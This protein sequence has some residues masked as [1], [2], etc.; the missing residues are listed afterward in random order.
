MTALPDRMDRCGIGLRAPHLDAV[1]G[2]QAD[3]A[4]VEIHAENHMLDGPGGDRLAAVRRD[5]PVSIHGVGLSLGSAG[6][7][8]R[9]HLSRL[10]RL[11]ERVE[12]VLVSEHLAWSVAG[13]HYWNDLLP[14]PLTAEALDVMAANVALVQD[15]LKRPILV[16]N[17]SSYLSFE[18]SEMGEGEFL[19][20]LARRTGCGVLLDLNNLYLS[21]CNLGRDPLADLEAM[22]LGC[23]GE[24]HLAGHTLVDLGDAQIRIDDHGSAVADAVW[25]LFALT[26]RRL[27]P[28]PALVEWDSAL[29][30]SSDCWRKPPRLTG[31][32]FRRRAMRL[33][34]LQGTFAQGLRTGEMPPALVAQVGAS[35]MAPARRLA[36]HRNHVRIT[37]SAA[38]ALHFPVVARLV[39]NEAFAAIANRFI[40]AHPPTDPVLSRFGALLPDFL[41]REEALS[42]L[43]Y[44]AAVAHLEWARHGAALAPSRAV[45]SAL[46]LAGIAPADLDTLSLALPPSAALIQSRWAVDRLWLANQE[47]C[48]GT[49]DGLIDEARRLAVWRDG[50]DMIRVAR[51]GEGDWAFLDAVA[52]GARLGDAAAAVVRAGAEAEL[53]EILA[54]ALGRGLL[55]RAET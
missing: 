23:V 47:G 51:L 22:P 55:C 44:V 54:A 8:D 1:A 45:F 40:A 38:L 21:A 34:E 3:P 7:I 9:D 41:A 17:P 42:G 49:P 19:G 35:G 15:A 16:E 43:P 30:R 13:G 53:G 33:A 31:R 24:I 52:K 36:I 29:P 50:G 28:V 48:D 25:D 12:P 26:R 4:W 14:L 46:G 2:G 39:G 20:H 10:V 32:R 37:L 18:A 11:V 5:R 6:G 27:G